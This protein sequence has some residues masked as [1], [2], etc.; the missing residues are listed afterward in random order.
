MRFR[1]GVEFRVTPP[2]RSEP[3]IPSAARAIADPF[4]LEPDLAAWV[5]RDATRQAL[6]S[7]LRSVRDPDHSTVLVGPTGIGKTLLLQRLA[8]EL[9]GE[10]RSVYLP[11]AGLSPSELC[12]WVLRLLGSPTTDDPV[13]VLWAYCRHLRSENSALLLEVDN[14]ESLPRATAERIGQLVAGSSGSLRW[15]LVGS[16][17]PHWRDTRAAVG[18]R[19]D[20]V[21]FDAPMTHEETR[22]YIDDRLER[23]RAP[24]ATCDR[25]D[26]AVVERLHA[27][28]G[29]IPGRLHAACTAILHGGPAESE[30]EAQTDPGSALPADATAEV[31]LSFE[32]DD[33]LTELVERAKSSVPDYDTDEELEAVGADAE[34]EP[35]F[36]YL[37]DLALRPR[38]KRIAAPPS[39]RGV[40]LGAVLIAAIT[41]LTP[42]ILS[43]IPSTRDSGQPDRTA[44]LPV[45]TVRPA[46]SEPVSGA[47]RETGTTA[48]GPVRVNVNA[49]PWAEIRIDGLDVGQ[50]PLADIP[51]LAGPH[52]FRAKLPDGRILER[53]V[54]I[55]AENRFIVFP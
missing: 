31:P 11:V 17:E 52:H 10:M 49:D 23:A 33:V 35:E 24:R 20:V 27:D 50:T 37:R 48:V 9:E 40:I 7:L 4:A 42:L 14:A 32:H 8:A 21:R 46:A 12:D 25:F 44:P 3:N 39:R 36:G 34:G 16:E 5:E 22:A 43:L 26:D 54:S 30:S 51:L 47:N 55:D 41:L 19:V 29:G 28:S 45:E 6:D 38:E 15:V 18:E 53:D 2:D 1:P 13:G